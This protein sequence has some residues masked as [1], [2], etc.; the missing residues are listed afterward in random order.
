M[1]DQLAK[2]RGVDA[3]KV[4]FA[5]S[6]NDIIKKGLL[7]FVFVD[8]SVGGFE[9]EPYQSRS[10]LYPFGEGEAALPPR[11]AMVHFFMDRLDAMQAADLSKTE[12]KKE[13]ISPSKI[14]KLPKHGAASTTETK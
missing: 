1:R 8:K 11:Y 10:S 3:S 14:E 7:P 12:T 4:L 5:P 2:E 6:A 13:K 9:L